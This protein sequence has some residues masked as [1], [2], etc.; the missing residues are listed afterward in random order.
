VTREADDDDNNNN[1]KKHT[2]H[3]EAGKS[4]VHSLTINVKFLLLEH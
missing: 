1:F 3:R 2:T 4:V